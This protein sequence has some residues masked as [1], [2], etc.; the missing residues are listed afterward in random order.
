MNPLRADVGISVLRCRADIPTITTQNTILS[1]REMTRRKHPVSRATSETQTPCGFIMR[2]ATR[3]STAWLT[4]G[5][6]NQGLQSLVWQSPHISGLVNQ[7]GHLKVRQVIS[8]QAGTSITRILT[9]QSSG[10]LRPNE[11]E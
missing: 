7:G 8:S 11:A 1:L 2:C 9:R 3:E 5:G 4:A 6:R 10:G